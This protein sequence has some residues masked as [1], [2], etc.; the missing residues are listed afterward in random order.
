MF[1]ISHLRL[2]LPW[3]GSSS[4]KQLLKQAALDSHLASRNK[5]P[6]WPEQTEAGGESRGAKDS[7]LTIQEKQRMPYLWTATES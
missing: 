7:D 2:S 4:N 5:R 3:S 6:L 1:V